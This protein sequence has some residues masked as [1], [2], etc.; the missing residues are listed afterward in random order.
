MKAVLL[1]LFALSAHPGDTGQWHALDADDDPPSVLPNDNRVAGGQLQH[2][3]LSISL[4]LALATWRPEGP[5]GP[6]VVVPAFSEEGGQPR[7]PAPLVRV[8]AGTIIRVA[9]RNNLDSA[10]TI[11]GLFTRPDTGASAFEMA[12]GDSRTVTFAAGEPGTYL[13]GA[14]PVGYPPPATSGRIAEREQ[15]FGALV[16]DPPEGSPPDRVLVIN[17]WGDT[18]G[19]ATYRNALTINGLSWPHTERMD[20]VT[21]D[22][23][24]WRV[25]NASARPHPMHLH[26][27]YFRVNARGSMERDRTFPHAE[28]RLVVT[29]NLASQT[30]MAMSWMPD[31]PGNWL[32]HCHLSFHA[33]PSTRL[34]AE[35]TDSSAHRMHLPGEHMAGLVLGIQ[36][37]PAPEFVEP[38][39]VGAR[40]LRLYAQEG[41]RLHHAPRSLGYVLQRD[42]R[43][44]APDSVDIPG[45][46]LVLERGQPTDIV[47]TNRLKESVAVHWH[48]LELESWSDGVAGWSGSEDRVA[49]AI[50]PGDSFVARLTQPRAGTF[51]YHTHINDID[52]LTSGLYGAIVVLE[53]GQPFDP[54]TDH[55]ILF[56]WD[57]DADPTRV[58]VNGDSA[59]APME[60]AAGK[61]HRLRFV[62]IG[63]ALTYT[64][65]LRRDSTLLSWRRLALDG[66][67]LPSHQS[68]VAP[69]RHRIA[70][71]QTADFGVQLDPGRYALQYAH[72]AIGVI[73]Q[74]VIVKGQE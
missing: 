39:R 16:V 73:E 7:I 42:E 22:S 30:T 66:A 44:P 60:I 65:S 64:I 1:A 41:Q 70:V 9:I 23:V 74:E 21:G 19:P 53:P 72:P 61:A 46:L 34:D 52:Q 50:A 20:G 13:Y 29:E 48:G 38:D 5:D 6:A 33:V 55:V 24:R 12:P 43:T 11:Q 63:P 40:R 62:N 14:T 18:A 47:V 69:A 17:I 58:L 8:P 35:M 49:P 57:G 68:V 15:T 25:V 27:F 54:A 56:S 36:V 2:D 45:S 26:G 59:P 28:R 67:D 37:R 10:M 32:F 31:R 71:G 3:T 4:V 51:I